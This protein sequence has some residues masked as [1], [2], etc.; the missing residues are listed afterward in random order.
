[1][2]GTRKVEVYNGKI[3]IVDS[4]NETR[5]L[6]D[7]QLTTAGY[8]TVLSTNGKDGLNS[9]FNENPDLVIID[10]LLSKFDGYEVCKNI[11]ETSHVPIL[12]LT[13]LN[14]ISNRVM[15][16][17]LGADDYL[18]KPYSQKELQAR[19]RSLL[20]RSN[21]RI[22]TSKTKK[23]N[24]I[25]VGSVI[26]NM[27]TQVISKNDLKIKLTPIEYKILA[28]LI[29]NNGKTLSR[30]TILDNVWGYT[31]ERVIDTRIVDVHISRLRT[32]I[33]DD[34]RRPDLILT[35]RGLGYMFQEYKSI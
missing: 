5:I 12:I 3:L 19:I 25:K 27:A 23:L 15:G 18:I 30:L 4:E 28:L 35:V 26:I 31:P 2:Q 21:N 32:K 6:L 16:L 13:G 8:K 10:I 11:R 29:Y 24:T 34:P 20:R 7:E 33:E 14:N 9:F 1:M 17:D 22:P